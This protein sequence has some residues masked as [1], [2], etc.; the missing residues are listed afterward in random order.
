M[1]KRFTAVR[2]LVVSVLAAY[3]L[4]GALSTGGVALPIGVLLLVFILWF[5]MYRVRHKGSGNRELVTKM[6]AD[7]K[8]T[9]KRIEKRIAQE[10]AQRRAAE[11]HEERARVER[12]KRRVEG[13]RRKASIT[14][15]DPAV[16]RY[17]E[18]IENKVREGERTIRGIE[19][20]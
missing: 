16:S 9:L 10:E 2:V 18:M 14:A 1:G 8:G 19:G 13:E 17:A 12:E 6:H 7:L 4:L 5:S 3:L 20:P 11:E 15:R